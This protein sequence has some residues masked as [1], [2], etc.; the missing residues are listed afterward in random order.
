M[1][2]EIHCIF[3]SLFPTSVPWFTCFRK[4]EWMLNIRRHLWTGFLGGS[5]HWSWSMY[6]E[7]ASTAEGTEP[8]GHRLLRFPGKL[9]EGQLSPQLPVVKS[10]LKNM[11]F[12]TGTFVSTEKRPTFPVE[13]GV[14][15]DRGWNRGGDDSQAKD[16][17]LPAQC[18]SSPQK[19]PGQGCV[20]WI[21]TK[22]RTGSSRKVL[23]FTRDTWPC[24]PCSSFKSKK[25]KVC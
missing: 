8:Q 17:V 10:T 19:H 22:R 7:T 9:S 13:T 4:D 25:S 15:Q 5:W 11:T 1:N 3:F 18:D 23:K 12:V 24:H 20:V 6:W 21:Y 16:V 2:L 14:V